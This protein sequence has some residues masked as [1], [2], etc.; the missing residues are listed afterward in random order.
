MKQCV[1]TILIIVCVISIPCLS[2]AQ[3]GSIADN[4]QGLQSVLDQLY[5][6]MLPLCSQLIG[7]GRGI[8]GFAAIW[9]IGSRVWRHIASAE[10]VDFYPL[11]RPFVLGFAILIFPSVIAVINGV[12]QPTVS[13]TNS[14]VTNSDQA[15]ATLLQ[16]KEAAIQKTDAWQMYVG[17]NGSGDRD[18]WYKYTHPDDP[19][20]TNESMFGSIGNDIKF[21]MSKASY[22]FR[23]SIKQWMSEVLQVLYEA[24]ALCINTIRTF[25]LIVLAILGPLV[26]GIAVFDGFQHTLTVWIARYINIFLWLP[27]SNIFGSIIGKIQQLMLQLDIRQVQTSGDTFFSSTD[28]AYLIF[29]IIGIVGYFTVPSVANYIVHAGGGNTLLYKTTSL[30]SN[31]SRSAINTVSSGAGMVADS[32]GNGREN[33]QRSMA[34]NSMTEGYFKDTGGN[35]SGSYQHDKLSGNTKKS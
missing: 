7:V 17:D 14:M 30:F 8:A 5:S 19:N 11:L 34:S 12:M 32:F 25:Y 29:L 21:A 33:V 26:F 27:V 13:A 9:Y 28:V 15:I 2:K 4:I 18:K 10:P 22:N 20:A 1:R 16:Q 24:A 35:S 31:S 23:N 3:A 6:E